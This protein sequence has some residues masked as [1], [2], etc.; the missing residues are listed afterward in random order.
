M[1][2]I[3][4]VVLVDVLQVAVI[5]RLPAELGQQQHRHGRVE[6]AQGRGA[7]AVF[8]HHALGETGGGVV[9]G[10]PGER[11]DGVE[12]PTFLATSFLMARYSRIDRSLTTFFSGMC[13]RA[14]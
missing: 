8:Q 10:Q 4:L 5:D 6:V 1:I 13:R 12:V 14:A 7:H 2:L 9:V 3:S 11:L